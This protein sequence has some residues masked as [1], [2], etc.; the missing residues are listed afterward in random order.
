MLKSIGNT[1]RSRNR[2]SVELIVIVH[3]GKQNEKVVCI[4]GTVRNS[5]MSV[6]TA[7]VDSRMFRPELSAVLQIVAASLTGLKIN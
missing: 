3:A 4:K 5:I 2:K 7:Q 1:M 6:T